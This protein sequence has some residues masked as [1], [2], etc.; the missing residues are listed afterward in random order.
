MKQSITRRS[1][2]KTAA[3]ASMAGTMIAPRLSMAA[4]ASSKLQHAAIGVA[5][6]GAYDLG[7]IFSSEKVD[8]VAL[9]DIDS[10]NLEIASKRYPGA[11]LY[12]DWR[13]MLDKE[14]DKIDSVNVSTPD[15]THA[16]ASITAIRN[17]LNTFCE[18]PLT[19]S[20]YE[21]RKVTEEARKAGVA[22]Q[23]GNQIHSHDFY[24]TA[25]QWMKD[26]AIGKIKG[27]H[28]WSAAR[29]GLRNEICKNGR[30]RPT[31][32]DPVPENVD[33]D[34]WLGVAP[35]R[36]FKLDYYHKF[37]WRLWRDFGSGETGDFGCHIF[38]PIFTAL[39][40]KD[41][42]S[43][44][45]QTENISE[46]MWP[47]WIQAEYLFKGTELCAGDTIVG[48]WSDGG[49]QPKSGLSPHLPNGFKLPGAGSMI[50]GEEGTMIVPHVKEP[51][52]YPEKK[53]KHY[54]KVDLITMNHYHDFVEGALG[55]GTPGSHFDYSGPMTEAV[56]LANIANR[57]PGKTLEWDAERLKF[58]NSKEANKFIRCKYRKGFKVIG[59]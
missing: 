47:H 41:P 40:V 14:S 17:G 55:N 52:I 25:V 19:H 24:R 15:H 8:V 11:R 43:I 56:L 29:Y 58:T 45:C 4:P 44:I 32:S 10:K 22:T 1:F 9:C 53:Y 6:Q 27:W 3:A 2:M 21:A 30:I 23:M 16:P 59:L 31:A 37:Y 7:Q 26:G 48:T 5:G 38:D 42:I 34:L 49:K 39:G 13:E 54:K 20:V 33:W 36:D 57:F 35:E 51:S 12:R 28:S 18:K 46:E 50:I